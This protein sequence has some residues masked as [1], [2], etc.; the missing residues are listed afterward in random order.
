MKLIILS[1]SIYGYWHNNDIVGGTMRIVISLFL[2]IGIPLLTGG[3]VYAQC[4]PGMAPA[5]CAEKHLKAGALTLGEYKNEVARV[6][7]EIA[8][9][10]AALMQQRDRYVALTTSLRTPTQRGTDCKTSGGNCVSPPCLADEIL[11]SGICL[12]PGE[13]PN[14]TGYVQNV[15]SFDGHSWN[16]NLNSIPRVG[17][18]Q[19]NKIRAVVWCAKI[20]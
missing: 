15:G 18:P 11:L 5:D 13:E 17:L 4:T 20:P 2:T 10:K 8:E 3:E 9:L 12:V 1:V 14:G 19:I 7:K 6:D 16:C